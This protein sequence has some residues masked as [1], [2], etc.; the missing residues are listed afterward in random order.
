[1]T[2]QLKVE[3]LVIRIDTVQAEDYISL[4]DIAQQNNQNKA[5]N[6]IAAW[7]R[8]NATLRSTIRFL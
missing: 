5:A 6:T 2:K 3:G 7:L 1:M 8:N 4:T